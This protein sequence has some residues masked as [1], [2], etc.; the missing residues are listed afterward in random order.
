M[1][2]DSD[3]ADLAALYGAPPKIVWLRCGNRSTVYIAD[4]IRRGAPQID[5]LNHA[6][7]DLLELT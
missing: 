4:L 1:T 2:L 7:H 6:E 3:F 5:A